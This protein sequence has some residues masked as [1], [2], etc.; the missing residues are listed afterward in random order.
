MTDGR[1][2]EGSETYNSSNRPGPKGCS[3][4][5]MRRSGWTWRWWFGRSRS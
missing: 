2:E 4:A 1:E 3:C 5:V